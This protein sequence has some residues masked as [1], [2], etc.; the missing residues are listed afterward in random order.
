MSLPEVWAAGESGQGFILPHKVCMGLNWLRQQLPR[1]LVWSV[2]QLFLMHKQRCRSRGASSSAASWAEDVSTE[3]QLWQCTGRCTVLQISV[4]FM[5][6]V[7]DCSLRCGLT[8][9]VD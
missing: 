9:S 2:D 1:A 5:N 6:A 7:T 4:G 8:F 3:L